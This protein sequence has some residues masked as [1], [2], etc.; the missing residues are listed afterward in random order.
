MSDQITTIT[1]A[2]NTVLVDP[3]LNSRKSIDEKAQ[4]RLTSSIKAQGIISPPLVIRAEQLGKKYAGTDRPLVLIAG[5]RRQNSLD[6]IFGVEAD[7]IHEYRLAP[8]SWDLADA[9]AANLTENLA[10]E[11][12]SP[13]ELATR[14]AELREIGLTPKEISQKVRALDCEQGDRK[15]LSETH[16]NNLVRCATQLQPEILEAW[17]V[18]HPRASVR[19][20]IQL[21]AEKDAATQL[22]MWKGIENPQPEGEGEGE[23]GEG[24]EGGGLK[25]PRDTRRRPT[26]PQL[27]IMIEGVKAAGKEGKREP[28]F[29][30]GAVA[31]LKYAA[32]LAAGIPGVKLAEDEEGEE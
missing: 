19:V 13:Y 26:R 4:D 12:I 1:A 5:F 21:A 16:I 2:R 29:V 30:R 6:S 23:G 22:S 31:A 8:E 14:C 18:Q 17:K 24:G 25:E 27:E 3:E 15:P 32:G 7:A 11:D 20:L 9:M 28:E 10:R